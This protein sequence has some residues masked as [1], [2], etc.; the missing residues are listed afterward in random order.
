MALQLNFAPLS[1]V[2]PPL[3]SK[4]AA[5]YLRMAVRT[6]LRYVKRREIVCSKTNGSYRFE[7]ADLQEF[8]AKRRRNLRPGKTR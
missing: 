2:V 1:E 4:E 5:A 3:T 7:F 8:I 6:L